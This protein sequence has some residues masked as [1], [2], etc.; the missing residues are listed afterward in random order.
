LYFPSG[1][2]SPD[3]QGDIYKI[4]GFQN[5][6]KPGRFNSKTWLN[7]LFFISTCLKSYLS[8]F[9]NSFGVIRIINTI[10]SQTEP[11]CRFGK[12]CNL[13]LRAYPDKPAKYFSISRILTYHNLPFLCARNFPLLIKFRK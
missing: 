5:R 13:E 12:I 4:S 10:T 2:E 6:Q 11:L 3:D 8:N 7:T 1:E 9:P